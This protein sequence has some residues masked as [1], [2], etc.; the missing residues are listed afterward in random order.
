MLATRGKSI[1][2]RIKLPRDKFPKGGKVTAIYVDPED[3]NEELR[4]KGKLVNGEFVLA[5]IDPVK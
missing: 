2:R 4:K 1:K 3:N 5:V